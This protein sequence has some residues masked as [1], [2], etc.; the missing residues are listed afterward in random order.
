MP[1][2]WLLPEEGLSSEQGV[3]V[4]H[5]VLWVGILVKTGLSS[6]KAT[7]IELVLELYG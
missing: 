5:G 2:G 1:P 3:S 6:V 7:D 4:D